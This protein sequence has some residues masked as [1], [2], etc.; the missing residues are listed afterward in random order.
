MAAD[1]TVLAPEEAGEMSSGQVRD[2]AINGVRWFSVTLGLAQFTQVAA[3]VVL[4]RLVSPTQFGRLAVALIV[5]EFALMIANETIG[6]P[7]V[8]RPEIEHEHLEAATLVALMIGFG[9]AVLTLFVVPLLTTPLFGAQTSVLFQLFAPAFAITGILIVPL[10]RLQR[11]LEFRRIGIS[12]VVGVLVSSAVSVGLAFLGL[13]AKAY[14]IGVMAGQLTAALGYFTGARPVR[15]RW[16]RRQMRELL[17]FGIPATAAGFAGVWYRNID[18][19]IL[20]ARLPT[21]IVGYYYRAFTVG[22]EYERRLSGIIARVAFPV[23]ART[24]DQIARAAMRHRI[25]R[26]N[27]AVVYPMLALFIVIAPTMVPWLFGARWQPAVLAAQI[28]AVAGMASTVR[29]LIA[30]AVLAAGRPRALFWFN[31]GE[32]LLYGTTVLVASSHGL[33]VVCVAVSVFQIISLIINYTVLLHSAVGAPRNQIIRDLGPTLVA[34]SVMLAIGLLVRRALGSGLPVPVTCAVVAAAGAPVYLAILRAL[35]PAAW[36]DLKMMVRTV[37]PRRVRNRFT[38][39]ARAPRA[40]APVAVPVV[41]ASP[42]TGGAA[43]DHAERPN[44]AQLPSL[45]ATRRRVVHRSDPQEPRANGWHGDD[46]AS[47][48]RLARLPVDTRDALEGRSAG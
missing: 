43:A 29:S 15:P 33:T 42:A 2:A 11:R 25:V 40:A 3:A 27:V 36:K 28:L 21:V 9:L 16:R 8:Q 12:E 17:S 31:L 19:M 26:V 44:V 10:A 32:T 47:G 20:G 5:S 14:V 46:R 38:R 7:L 41:A 37:T 35:S 39:T 18:Y 1:T 45:F 4:A 6:T 30:P 23:Y 13:G 22:V 24:K 34:T 48:P